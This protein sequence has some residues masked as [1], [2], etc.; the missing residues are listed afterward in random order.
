MQI[1]KIGEL[2][3]SMPKTIGE[4]IPIRIASEQMARGHFRHLPVLHAGRTGHTWQRGLRAT[5]MAAPKSISA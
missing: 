2:M 4:D 5:Q 1:P 3:T